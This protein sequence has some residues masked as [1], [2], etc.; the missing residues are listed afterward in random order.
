MW[1]DYNWYKTEYLLGRQPTLPELGYEF[2]EKKARQAINPK[3]IV[4]EFIP[5]Y[6]KECT[7]ELAEHLF[8]RAVNNLDSITSFSNDG[9]SET[10]QNKDRT[11]DIISY[12]LSDTELHNCFVF[13]GVE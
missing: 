12:H 1:V 5:D 6:L 10:R 4:L 9:Y 13:V 7:C 3:S 2:W 11:R 8:Y